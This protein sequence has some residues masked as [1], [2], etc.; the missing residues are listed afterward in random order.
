MNPS[1]LSHIPS[2]SQKRRSNKISLLNEEFDLSLFLMISQKKWKLLVG[3][4]LILIIGATIYLRYAQRIY[5]ENC[6]IQVTSQNT[7]NKVLN[8]ASSIYEPSGDEVAEAV[9]LMR[10]KVF[11]EKVFKS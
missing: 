8:S 4:F 5:E 11:L 2:P 9:E 1:E 7:A 10:S 6:I 3:I